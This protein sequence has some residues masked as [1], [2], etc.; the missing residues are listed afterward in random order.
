MRSAVVK[1]QPSGLSTEVLLSILIIVLICMRT[2]AV[3]V[4][5]NVEAVFLGV[6]RGLV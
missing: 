5:E 6:V 4:L 2:R 3:Q 1:P